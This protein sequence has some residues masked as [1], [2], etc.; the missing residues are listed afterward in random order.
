MSEIKKKLN[1]MKNRSA[2]YEFYIL[3]DVLEKH[4]PESLDLLL[5]VINKYDQ[6]ARNNLS[7]KMQLE[8]IKYR[9]EH[10]KWDYPKKN[11]W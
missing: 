7:Y 5:N 10:K 11:Q 4:S 6:L 2:H 3:N 9:Q 8:G 1:S